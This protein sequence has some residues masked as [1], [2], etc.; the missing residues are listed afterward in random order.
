MNTLG[1]DL[2]KSLHRRAVLAAAAAGLICIGQ[3]APHALAADT[4]AAEIFRDN[5]ASC[6]GEDAKGLKDLGVDLTVSP[7]VK[8]MDDAQFAEFLKIGRQ[9]TERGSRTGQ[10]M[11]AFDYLTPEETAAAIAFVRQQVR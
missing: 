6:H 3:D 1:G 8:Q 7:F 11:P 4:A 5:C 9:A 2:M 10:M